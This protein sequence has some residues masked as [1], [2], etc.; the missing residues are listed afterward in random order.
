[1]NSSN[2]D[3]HMQVAEE[4]KY[5]IYPIP[6]EL[7]AKCAILWRESGYAEIAHRLE[8]VARCS[9]AWLHPEYAPLEDYR[10]KLEEAGVSIDIYK[11]KHLGDYVVVPPE[12]LKLLL[13]Q[14]I[15]EYLN[16]SQSPSRNTLELVPPTP[17]IEPESL[18]GHAVW[19]LRQV[20]EAARRGMARVRSRVEQPTVANQV[21]S[22]TIRRI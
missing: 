18:L 12:A 5:G 13:R 17:Q 21:E 2:M 19:A 10:K 6:A 22:T 4:L 1:M 16:R 11:S 8:E 7:M 9:I 20:S 3:N 15:F 14:E